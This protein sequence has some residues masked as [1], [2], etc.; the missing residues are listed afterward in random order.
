[1]ACT[2]L[3]TIPN[4][5]TA[6]SGRAM[7]NVIERLDRTRF[8][9][10]VCVLRK[11]GELDREVERLGIPFLE[12]PFTVPARPYS[13]LLARARKASEAFRPFGFALWHSFHYADDY[14]E[15][16]I[17]R[18]AGAR[19]WVYTKKNMNWGRRSW[20]LRTLLATRVAAQNSDMM[21]DFFACRPFRGK[22]CPVARGV[23]IVKFQP[24]VPRRLRLREEWNIPADAPLAACV[25]HLVPVKGHPELLQASAQVSGLHL[26]LAGN[27]LDPDY[28]ASLARMAHDLK[29]EDRVHFLGGIRDVPALLSEVDLSVL[30]NSGRG[31]GCPVAVLEA[32]ACGS[33][34]V[35]ADVPGSRDLVE[36]GR[37]GWLVPPRNP[38][39]LARALDQLASSPDLRRALG[40]AARARVVQQFSIEREVA[41]HE[42]LYQESLSTTGRGFLWH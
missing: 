5:I 34:C 31:E 25:A 22:T 33:T 16:I 4:F 14:T 15:P 37:S 6:G 30:P 10:A 26:L 23:D 32:M 8:A 2:L 35:V 29:I 1:M 12:A 38:Q 18:L 41:A 42:A 21:R 7:L 39:A 19:A 20:Y 36:H 9:P 13:T 27:P 17:A 11:G 28:A 40:E 3:F 24:G